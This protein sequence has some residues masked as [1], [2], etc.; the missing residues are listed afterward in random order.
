[1]S[2][3][4]NKINDT[5]MQIIKRNILELFFQSMVIFRR[6]VVIKSLNAYLHLNDVRQ[7]FNIIGFNLHCL[8]TDQNERQ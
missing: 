2:V 6:S 7:S 1:M 8:A 4:D 5:S 3:N